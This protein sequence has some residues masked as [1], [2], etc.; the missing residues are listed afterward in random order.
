MMA[1][2]QRL[3]QY[4][5]AFSH[6]WDDIAAEDNFPHKRPL[7]A[8]YTSV[9]T[10][11]C[12]MRNDEIWF[13]NPLYMNDIEELRFGM[14]E[15]AEAFRTHDA[16]REAC[17]DETRYR[18]LQEV[19]EEQFLRFSN[20]HAFDT[21]VL[22]FSVHNASDS[23]GLLSM[24]R[25]YGGNG[26]GAAIVIDTAKFEH[27]G[28]SPLIVSRVRYHST[29]ERMN[30]I[31]EL[32]KNF[33]SRLANLQMPLEDL[34]IAAEQ[35][36][37]RLLTF[38]LFT[39]HSGFSEENE[40]RIVYL[41]HRDRHGHLAMML[42]YSIGVR[43]LEPKLKF[44]IAPNA[45]TSADLSLEKIVDRVILGPSISSPLAVKSMQRMLEHVGKGV[46]ANKVFAS[47]TPYRVAEYR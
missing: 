43:G 41:K 38:A 34:H 1:T 12:V 23:D 7:L 4:F 36:L 2:E 28:A 35:F 17:A 5:E 15:G 40:W 14:N 37:Q 30:M 9:S 27:L 16:I 11:E 32:L 46:F 18:H 26:S 10:L 24:W 33:A 25:G 39:K 8:H 42:G 13:S 29:N 31:D 47:S 21:Y 22:C 6:L 20:E 44:K 3:A 45:A 19:F